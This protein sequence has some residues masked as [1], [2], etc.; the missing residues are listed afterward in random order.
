[1]SKHWLVLSFVLLATVAGCTRTSG[2][3]D[4]ETAKSGGKFSRASD[5]EGPIKA[6]ATVGMVADIVRNVG[7]KHVEVTQLMGPGVDPHLYKATR[8]DVGT[9]MSGE[10]IFYSGL[11]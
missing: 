9:L 8:D 11:M 7:G 3:S 5:S 6:V 2:Q 10:V 1:M 4:A